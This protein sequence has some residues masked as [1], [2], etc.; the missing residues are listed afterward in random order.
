[1]IGKEKRHTE[2]NV[3]TLFG[4]EIWLH[5]PNIEQICSMYQ[6]NNIT[7]NGASSLIKTWI[8]EEFINLS[9]SRNTN[10]RPSDHSS[11]TSNYIN[12]YNF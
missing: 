8:D 5:R 2:L 3:G 7:L 12:R 10:F 4:V 6:L 9:M 1:M 11:I